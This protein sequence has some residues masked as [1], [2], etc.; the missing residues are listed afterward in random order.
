MPTVGL[1]YSLSLRKNGGA[2]PSQDMTWQYVHIDEAGVPQLDN[3]ALLYNIGT[4]LGDAHTRV[5]DNGAGLVEF[6]GSGNYDLINHPPAPV[7]MVD[8][9]TIDLQV[10]NHVATGVCVLE[11]DDY[12]EI[13]AQDIPGDLSIVSFKLVRIGIGNFL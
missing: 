8:I 3:T 7:Q 13:G 4:G 12:A 6:N 9:I 11:E 1:V 10:T 5:E 2:D